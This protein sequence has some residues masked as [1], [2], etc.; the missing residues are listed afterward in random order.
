MLIRPSATLSSSFVSYAL[1]VGYTADKFIGPYEHNLDQM[2]CPVPVEAIAMWKHE[3]GISNVVESSEIRTDKKLTPENIAYCAMIIFKVYRSS[4]TEIFNNLDTARGRSTTQDLQGIED[5]LKNGLPDELGSEVRER[6]APRIE[7]LRTL[8]SAARIVTDRALYQNIFT[9]FLFNL[10]SKD[11][12]H[13]HPTVTDPEAYKLW[14]KVLEAILKMEGNDI[15][16]DGERL[17]MQEKAQVHENLRKAIAEPYSS[18]IKF[19]PVAVVVMR[20]S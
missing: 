18:V 16:S 9:E 15:I 1:I 6:L 13:A 10:S 8:W 14:T 11:Q 17:A 4:E 2:P 20:G 12:L 7:C 5:V 3:I 19:Q